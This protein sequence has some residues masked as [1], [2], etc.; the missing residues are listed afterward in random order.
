MGNVLCAAKGPRHPA[1][2]EV[3]EDML[4]LTDITKLRL[5]VG[6]YMADQA[7]YIYW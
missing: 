6:R 5:S 7:T 1:N 3:R 4:D 2:T